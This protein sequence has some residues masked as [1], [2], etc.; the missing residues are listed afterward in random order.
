[1]TLGEAYLKDILRPPPTSGVP[2]N[3]QHPFQKSFYTYLTKKAIPRHWFLAVGFTCAITLYGTLDSLREGGKQKS[4][5][6]A[7]MEGRQPCEC[8]IVRKSGGHGGCM[9]PSVPIRRAIVTASYAVGLLCKGRADQLLLHS[10]TPHHLHLLADTAG[11][12]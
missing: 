11:G 4:Y 12:H 5:D 2:Q 10:I 9:G 8:L 3:V 1:M 6:Q 7:V